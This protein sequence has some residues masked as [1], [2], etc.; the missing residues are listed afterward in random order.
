MGRLVFQVKSGPRMTGKNLKTAGLTPDAIRTLA[1]YGMG[2]RCGA[3]F[4][5]AHLIPSRSL[6]SGHA[7]PYLLHVLDLILVQLRSR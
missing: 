4:F 5:T 7:R 1:C 6:V 3:F 2:N